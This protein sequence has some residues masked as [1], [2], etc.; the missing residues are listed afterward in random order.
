MHTQRK[1]LSFCGRQFAGEELSLIQEVVQTCSG[2]S[3]TELAYTVCELLQWKRAN[4]GL[5]A[6]ECRDLLE[7][8]ESRGLLTLPEKKSR[9]PKK[10]QGRITT[11]GKEPPGIELTGSVESFAPVEVQRVQSP[12]QRLLFRELVSRYHYLGYAMPYGARLQYLAYVSR[13]R[14]EVVG[15]IQFSSPAWR[16]KA[17]DQWIGWDDATRKQRLQHVVNNSRLLIIPRIRNLASTLLSCVLRR[18]RCDWQRQYGL[19][20]WLVETLVDGQRFHG[21]CYRAANWIELGRTSGRGRMDRTHQRHGA[22]VKTVLVYPL[23]KN[24]AL[25]LRG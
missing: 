19:E 15:C 1:N 6:R 8:L 7:R 18:L 22:H 12:Q 4:G 11:T 25:R 17:R 2:I 21:G 20:P 13:P 5:K 16:M 23:V 9:G 3:R 10:D 14:R 24:A